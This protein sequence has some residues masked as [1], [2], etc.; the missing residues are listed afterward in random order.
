M[1]HFIYSLME[2]LAIASVLAA[3]GSTVLNGDRRRRITR[4]DVSLESILDGR[5]DLHEPKEFT[6][7]TAGLGTY[8]GCK[9]EHIC[10]AQYKI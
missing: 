10:C 2:T 9:I 3:A 7:S 6:I 5:H 8:G 1:H 4:L